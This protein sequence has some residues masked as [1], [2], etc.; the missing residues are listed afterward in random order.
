ME[1]ADES[2]SKPYWDVDRSLHVSEI[3]IVPSHELSCNQRNEVSHHSLVR[4]NSNL[5]IMFFDWDDINLIML[6]IQ[7]FD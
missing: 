7:E 5:C 1:I 3:A 4:S 6:L 2:E